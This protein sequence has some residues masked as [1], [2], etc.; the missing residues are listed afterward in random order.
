LPLVSYFGFAQQ[1]LN[2]RLKKGVFMKSIIMPKSVQLSEETKQKL[3]QEVKET[4]AKE[5]I[6]EEK[7]TASQMWKHQKQARSA[8]D[9]MR[10]WNLN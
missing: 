8:S 10:R 1:L 3:A 9:M 4:I 5:V 7:F 6:K 2:D